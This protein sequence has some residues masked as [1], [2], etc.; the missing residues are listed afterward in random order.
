MMRMVNYWRLYN[1][2]TDSFSEIEIVEDSE[3]FWVKTPKSSSHSK[4]YEKALDNVFF[5]LGIYTNR[6]YKKVPHMFTE[7]HPL[8][9]YKYTFYL[10]NHKL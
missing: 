3:G 2:E 5:I 9:E 10:K 1:A 4:T 8:Y 7:V 6:G